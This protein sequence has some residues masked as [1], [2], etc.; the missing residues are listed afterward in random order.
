MPRRSVVP[1]FRF[2]GRRRR[3]CFEVTLPGTGGRL[4]RRKT[5]KASTRE[6]ALKLFAQF[7]AAAL[8]ERNAKPEFFSDYVRLFW[9]MVRMRLGART[10]AEESLVVEKILNPFFG[11]YRL[12]KI[13]GDF[14]RLLIRPGLFTEPCNQLSSAFE[15]RGL[16]SRR[17]ANGRRYLAFAI[18]A[19][20]RIAACHPFSL[21]TWFFCAADS[22]LT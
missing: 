6:E 20:I 7:R 14:L 21:R 1:G 13:S 2:D 4:R 9:P 8:S 3:A 22:R 18:P 11:S 17:F 19:A 12:E 16:T 5:V 15:V 10:A